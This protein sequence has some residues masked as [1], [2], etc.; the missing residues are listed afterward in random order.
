MPSDFEHGLLE[1]LRKRIPDLRAEV[2]IE[3]KGKQWMA[4]L[5]SEK[6]ALV[7]EGSNRR[8]KRHGSGNQ[9]IQHIE[10][11]HSM[12]LKLIDIKSRDPAVR[13]VMVWQDLIPAT[14]NDLKLCS[15]WGVYVLSYGDFRISQVLE[16]N[17]VTEVNKAALA[18]L[19]RRNADV[20]PR[21]AWL[22]QEERENL[23]ATL[24]ERAMTTRDI[25]GFLGLDYN[26]TSQDRVRDL[27]IKLIAEGGAL[28]LL[29]GF[30][31]GIGAVF[32][33]LESQLVELE[34]SLF[35]FYKD[36]KLR[37]R[38]GSW[39]LWLLSQE[40][41]LTHNQISLRLQTRWKS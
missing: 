34:P 31:Q 20:K 15:R 11:F 12:L 17:P 14:S 36:H 33:T 7:I 37:K 30:S 1:S 27:M 41:G 38:L 5:F 24:G 18:Y 23:I 26:R 28:K 21:W 29:P 3:G 32:G 9:G 6:Y 4:N 40:P 35:P 16:D 10:K 19:V 39:I 25:A 13:P 2:K 22:R 8:I